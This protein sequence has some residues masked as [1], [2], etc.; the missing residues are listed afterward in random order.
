MAHYTSHLRFLLPDTA[1]IELPLFSMKVA[2]GFPSPADDHVEGVLDLNRYLIHHPAATFMVRATGDSMIGAGIHDGDLLMVDRALEAVD[3]S[4]VLAIVNG[5]FTV[6]RLRKK[7]D[8]IALHAE[9]PRFEPIVIRPG[10]DF[11]VWGVVTNVIHTLL[12]GR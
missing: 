3:K 11:E 12:P 9:N 6:K 2:A 8:S 1:P 10:M 7:G 4:V 5:E